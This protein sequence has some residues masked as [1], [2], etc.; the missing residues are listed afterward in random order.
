MS[1]HRTPYQSFGEFIQL[2]RKR[3]RLSQ[4]ALSVLLDVDRA[5]LSRIECGIKQLATDKLEPLADVFKLKLAEVQREFYADL[6]VS[7]ILRNNCPESVLETAR[8]KV[9]YLKAMH[10]EP[11]I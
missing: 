9:K 7:E 1:H 11:V 2:N 6:I 4:T 8:A 3:M 10:K 5:H